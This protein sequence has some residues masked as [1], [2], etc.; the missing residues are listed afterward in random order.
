MYSPMFFSSGDR[1]SVDKLNYIAFNQLANNLEVLPNNKNQSLPRF[2]VVLSLQNK[3]KTKE[4]QNCGYDSGKGLYYLDIGV[5][6]DETLVNVNKVFNIT[7]YVEYPIIDIDFDLGRVYFAAINSSSRVIS[8]IKESKY[9]IKY[10]VKEDR[11]LN[12]ISANF[13][14][15]NPTKDYNAIY[16]LSY[17]I[18]TNRFLVYKVE[19]LKYLE[20]MNLGGDIDE[21]GWIYWQK[22]INFETSGFDSNSGWSYLGAVMPNSVITIDSD[23]NVSLN[24][25]GTILEHKDV[26]VLSVNRKDFSTTFEEDVTFNNDVIMNDTVTFNAGAIFNQNVSIERN[27]SVKGTFSVENIV[28]FLSD[29]N[30][31][32]NVTIDGTATLNNDTTINGDLRVNGSISAES[33]VGD[34]EHGTPSSPIGEIHTTGVKAYSGDVPGSYKGVIYDVDSVRD[35]LS[36]FNDFDWFIVTGN[37][38]INADIGILIKNKSH[39]MRIGQYNGS[40]FV[41]YLNITGYTNDNNF[42]LDNEK[43]YRNPLFGTARFTSGDLAYDTV[44]NILTE[45]TDTKLSDT[46]GDNDPGR[47]WF[48]TDELISSN[49]LNDSQFIATLPTNAYNDGF[50]NSKFD[51]ADFA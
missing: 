45:F 21:T 15:S 36:E 46:D 1:L 11:N 41:D 37:N 40:Y 43:W 17:N 24:Y 26:I 38:T 8:S 23:V 20:W 9:L 39:W 7:K 13:V 4:I 12:S 28:D 42:S 3:L 49:I 14:N 35:R 16:L 22:V 47:L 27:L 48:G 18:S 6:S 2:N 33:I 25:S 50:D 10:Y 31:N 30:V 34:I 19:T 44:H 5:L 32:G 51:Y 29:L